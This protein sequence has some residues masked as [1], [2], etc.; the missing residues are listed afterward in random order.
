ML[1]LEER[2]PPNEGVDCHA[3]LE[4]GLGRDK[5]F[6]DEVHWLRRVLKKDSSEALAAEACMSPEA[7]RWEDI[8]LRQDLRTLS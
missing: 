8:A 1:L 4:E 3:K 6:E 7:L 5:T 2:A